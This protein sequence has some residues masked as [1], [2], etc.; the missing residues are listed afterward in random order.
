MSLPTEYDD[1]REAQAKKQKEEFE[2]KQKFQKHFD[3]P[4]TEDPFERLKEKTN[5]RINK[6]Y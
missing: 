6:N 1:I 4:E 2:K 5:E 3:V